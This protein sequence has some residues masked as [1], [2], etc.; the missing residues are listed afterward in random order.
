M[1]LELRISVL[2]ALGVI[3]GCTPAVVSQQEMARAVEG[4]I[5]DVNK[6]AVVDCLLP[7]QMRKL[8]SSMSYVSAR[9]PVRTTEADCEVRGGEY[10]AYDRANYSSALNVWLEKAKEGDAT[11]QLYVGQIYEKGLGR[12]P[13]YAEAAAWYR[14]SAEQGNSQAQINLGQ[15]YEKGLGVPKQAQAAIELYAKATGLERLGVDYSAATSDKAQAVSTRSS[16]TQSG[17]YA[18]T[19]QSKGGSED[20]QQNAELKAL[21]DQLQQAQ[22]QVIEQQDKLLKTQTALALASDDKAQKTTA[23]DSGSAA[24]VS[25][26]EAELKKTQQSL[27]DEQDR[28]SRMNRNIQK[29]RENASRELAQARKTA[30]TNKQAASSSAKGDSSRLE[31][32]KQEAIR[33]QSELETL[34]QAFTT[35]S[36]EL[37]AWITANAS[38]SDP[39]M[40]S[41]I[42][43]RK[44]DLQ[45]QSLHIKEVK[46]KLTNANN[47]I[48]KIEAEQSSMLASNGPRIEI[49]DPPTVLT[50]GIQAI[51]AANTKII[52]GRIIPPAIKSLSFNGNPL[53]YDSQGNFAL[54]LESATAPNLLI[55]AITAS[56]GE[57][58]ARF[59][60]MDSNV[61]QAETP[62]GAASAPSS[63]V[64][65]KGI[66]LGRFYAL[67]IGNSD[68]SRYPHLNT[69]TSDAKSV[70]VL[71]RERYGF[72]TR[73][74][75]NGNR[76]DIMTAFNEMQARVSENDNLLIYYAGHGEIDAKT[77][78]AYW[79]PVDAEVGNSANWIAS[80]SV[81]DLIGIMP[82]RHVMVVSDS[83]YSGA[84]SGSAVAKLPPD[85]DAEKKLKWLK[86]MA[87][88]KGRTVLTSGEVKP[89]LDS[90]GDGHSVFAQSF[91]KAL[92]SGKGLIEDYEIYRVVS[93]EVSQAAGRLGFSQ[94]PT[95]APLQYAGHE[96]SP[97]IFRPTL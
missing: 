8:G 25:E 17:A 45:Q 4:Y 33:I 79:L 14:K 76:H 44:Q 64:N 28:L 87:T 75:V 94:T 6:L 93:Q 3:L 59:A 39:G 61:G 71:L 57:V 19:I 29:E 37:T 52:K 11:A 7:G 12:S 18:I 97:F 81:T 72:T 47:Q 73:M 26:L 20:A 65:P 24:R 10:V 40:R 34:L 63:D 85:I 22:Q 23:Q 96:G 62:S 54:N 42:D 27:K 53:A 51:Q 48:A 16:G 70:E 88:R 9:R 84:M 83:C 69:P 95:Y 92:R 50:R 74:I 90:G 5:V 82:A 35:Q 67:I 91:L 30:E 66:E 31:E 13:D 32:A 15:L 36:T 2:S 58:E 77:K 38:K 80:K 56:G 49:T 68:Y 89:V 78:E 1:K 21:R 60:L 86:V 41:K 43:Q 55:K 46:A